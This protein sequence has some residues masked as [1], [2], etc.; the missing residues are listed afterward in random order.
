L[1]AGPNVT[2]SPG[3]LVLSAA[4]LTGFGA[5]SLLIGG[6]RS[7]SDSGT[8]VS[9]KTNNLTVDNS[10]SPLSAPDLILVANHDLTLAN[11]ADVEQLGTLSGPADALL[12]G[13]D[14]I[15]GSGNGVLLRVS[16]DPG[17]EIARF[18]VT[19]S[20]LPSLTI[21]AGARISGVSLILD[22]T[23]ATNLDPNAILTGQSVALDS[24]QISLELDNPGTLLPTV[25]LV[26]SNTALQS[27]LSS[28][29]SLSLLSY[30]SIDI[31]G[32]GHVGDLDSKSEP[33]VASL[34]LHAAELRGFNN[35]GGTVTF[36]AKDITLDNSANVTGPGSVTA[37]DGTLAFIADTLHLASNE[38][39]IDQFSNVQLNASHGVLVSRKGSLQTN[40]ALTVTAPLIGGTT[41]ADYTINS[42]G[43][44]TFNAPAITSSSLFMSGLGVRLTLMGATVTVD[45][46][47]TLPSGELTL[48][49]TDGDVVIGDSASTTLDVSGTAQTFFDVIKYTN[50]GVINLIA[51]QGNVNVGADGKLSVDAQTTAGDAG[52][53]SVSVPDGAFVLN[54][55]MSGQAGANGKGGSFTLDV[56]QL[57]T[58][59]SLDAT[60]NAGGF[61]ESRSIRVRTGDVLIDGLATSHIFNLSADGGSITV[62]GTIDS[63][64]AIG[65]TIDLVAHGSL[66]LASGAMLTVAAQDFNSAG[67]GGAVTL[68]AGA[69]TNGTFDST[70]TLDIQAGSTIDLSVARDNASSASLGDF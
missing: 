30:S 2:G 38:L 56:S 14:A 15:A 7:A 60:L 53:V 42:A 48:H 67:K 61:L 34:A 65:G 44:F 12:L 29:Q 5:E 59:G 35:G 22:S 70:A 46:N 13:S 4:G 11:G 23:N 58:L 31:Y 36:A 33:V 19:A 47:V 26:L 68:E 1:I 66:T 3:E 43:A 52:S 24:G 50:G 28:T 16:A 45:S 21:G 25:G 69:E 55:T 64:G 27:L 49:A 51:D 32:T 63:S 8:I 41:G 18:G 37:N 39:A 6:I 10:G 62:T 54:G 57:A 40:G 9:V 20:M 17:A